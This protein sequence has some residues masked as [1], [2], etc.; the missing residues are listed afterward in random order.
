MS[1]HASDLIEFASDAGFAIDTE[2]RVVAW[3]A[4]AERLLGYTSSEV[5]GHYCRDVLQAAL[6]GGEPLCYPVVMFPSVL[7][8]VSLTVFLPAGYNTRMVSGYRPVSPRSPCRNVP[9]VRAPTISWP[10]FIS[11]RGDNKK[12]AQPAYPANFYPWVLRSDGG[13]AWY[14]D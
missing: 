5:I 12:P 4:L 9:A 10:L 1:S 2:S 13:R 14:C 7:K 6:P 11:G 8:S 3:N